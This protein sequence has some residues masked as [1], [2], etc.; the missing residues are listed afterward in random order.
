MLVENRHRG[1]HHT[2]QIP[3]EEIVVLGVLSLLDRSSR[4]KPKLTFA[5]CLR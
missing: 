4:S 2:I 5:V 1:A 3:I